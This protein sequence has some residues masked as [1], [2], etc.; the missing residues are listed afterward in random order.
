MRSRHLLTG[1]L[2]FAAFG[3]CAFAQSGESHLMRYADIHGDQ[4]VFTYEG[5]LW[6]ASARGG[7]ARRIT[8]DPGEERY[9]NDEDDQP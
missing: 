7:D 5:D 4:I 6:L 1:L 3:L 2:F 9:A 8:S